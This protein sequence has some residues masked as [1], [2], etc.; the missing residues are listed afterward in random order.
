MPNRYAATCYKCGNEVA[1]GAG[2]FERIG[3]AQRLKWPNLRG[4][5]WHVQHHECVNDYPRTAHYL[6]NPTR[7]PDATHQLANRRDEADG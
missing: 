4:T 5:V 2:V 1:A 7:V 3:R 6:H